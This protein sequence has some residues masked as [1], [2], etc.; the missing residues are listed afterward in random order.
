MEVALVISFCAFSI[1]FIREVAKDIQDIRGDAFA[2]Y[3]TLPVQYGIK[4]ALLVLRGTL[5]FSILIHTAVLLVANTQTQNLTLNNLWVWIP[6]FLVILL[7]IYLYIR[8]AREYI[9]MERLSRYLKIAMFLGA[10]LPYYLLLF[11]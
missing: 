6:V 11:L 9:P 7:L 2:R 4:R 5:L 3:Q 1:N 10:T 8:M